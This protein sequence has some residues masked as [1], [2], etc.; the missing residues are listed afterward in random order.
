MKTDNKRKNIQKQ[1]YEKVVVGLNQTFSELKDVQKENDD[2]KEQ[3]KRANDFILDL[4]NE[5]PNTVDHY[6]DE[7]VNSYDFYCD[8]C[9]SGIKCNIYNRKTEETIAIDGSFYD[10]MKLYKVLKKFFESGE[11]RVISKGW[12]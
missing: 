6:F 7:V 1:D 12:K 2:L 4:R 11:E 3:I 10:V 9:S 5:F 8:K